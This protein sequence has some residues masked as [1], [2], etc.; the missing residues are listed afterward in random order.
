MMPHPLL[1]PLGLRE[2]CIAHE[3]K[4]NVGGFLKNKRNRTKQVKEA[5]GLDQSPQKKNTL[6]YWTTNRAIPVLTRL[7][8]RGRDP[9][10]Y[11]PNTVPFNQVREFAPETVAKNN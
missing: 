7:V 6:G 4:T 10:V 5:F 8:N 3:D 2:G 9:I 11:N 1:C